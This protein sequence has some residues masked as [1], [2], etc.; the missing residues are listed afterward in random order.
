[1]SIV[2]DNISKTPYWSQKHIDDGTRIE[3][4]SYVLLSLNNFERAASSI[5]TLRFSD[6]SLHQMIKRRSF[7][8]KWR[9]STFQRSLFFW[10]FISSSTLSRVNIFVSKFKTKFD[11]IQKVDHRTAKLIRWMDRNF[12]YNGR[13][14]GNYWFRSVGS[15]RS[16]ETGWT[17]FTSFTFDFVS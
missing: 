10:S 2:N 14:G 3:M 17:H 1:M 12:G 5:E 9:M 15:S 11:I 6:I 7:M 13:F 4:T 8:S 16:K